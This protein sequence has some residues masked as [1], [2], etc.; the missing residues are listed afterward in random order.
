MPYKN[1]H[2]CRLREPSEFIEGTF[3]RGEREHEGKRYSVIYGKLKKTGKMAEQAFRYPKKVWGVDEA[4]RHCRSHGGILFEPARE[5]E[6]ELKEFARILQLLGE[7]L[8]EEKRDGPR[9]R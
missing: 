3:R 1:E 8:K 5:G 2:A 6:D 7:S 4:R 9:R